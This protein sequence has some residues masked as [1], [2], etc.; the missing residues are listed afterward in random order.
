M[1]TSTPENLKKKLASIQRGAYYFGLIGRISTTYGCFFF[2]L[3]IASCFKGEEEIYRWGAQTL[4]SS[5]T[6]LLYGWLF[7][8]GRDALEAISELITEIGE[9]V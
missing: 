8:L 4:A 1:T 7:L 5:I 3:F 6:P 9:I 2:L